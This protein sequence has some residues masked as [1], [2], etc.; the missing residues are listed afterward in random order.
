[1]KP[2][3]ASGGVNVAVTQTGGAFSDFNN[4]SVA[5]DCDVTPADI[6][7]LALHFQQAG[8]PL[9]ELASP[10]RSTRKKWRANWTWSFAALTG[11]C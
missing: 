9:G 5:L 2:G 8:A 3:S 10:G 11:G 4:F 6:K 1:M 7:Q